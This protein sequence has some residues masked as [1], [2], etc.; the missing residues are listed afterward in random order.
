M[1]I[2]LL[3]RLFLI[4]YSTNPHLH[5]GAEAAVVPRALPQK[6]APGEAARRR[7]PLARQRQRADQLADLGRVE[8][9]GLLGAVHLHPVGRHLLRRLH[10]RRVYSLGIFLV[11]GWTNWTQVA[12][13]YS[14]LPRSETRCPRW[15]STPGGGGRAVCGAARA[16]PPAP[17]PPRPPG[18]CGH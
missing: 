3:L 9:V 6:A 7:V 16:P 14:I 8:A 15:W 2:L 11:S 12:R 10:L 18:K 1:S 4:I 5:G 17:S 13:V